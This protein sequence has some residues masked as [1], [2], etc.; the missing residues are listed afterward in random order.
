[1]YDDTFLRSQCYLNKRFVWELPF[2]EGYNVGGGGHPWELKRDSAGTG[3]GSQYL[4]DANNQTLWRLT[5]AAGANNYAST[6][7][8]WILWS[9][10][11]T[12][13]FRT[14]RNPEMIV[15]CRLQ[16]LTLDASHYFGF[17][18]L[19]AAHHHVIAYRGFH[20]NWRLYNATN[21]VNNIVDT[22]IAADTNW[23]TLK[24]KVSETKS[25]LYRSSSPTNYE[26]WTL[27]AENS[28]QMPDTTRSLFGTARVNT[29][30]T[31]AVQTAWIRR[32]M[33]SQDKV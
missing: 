7:Y 10:N 1:M 12:G 2:V 18:M 28:L 26:D 11:F 23:I 25:E 4:R 15:T 29:Q 17:S 14:N 3:S 19:A 20:T 33:F 21:S 22:G 13:G 16:T 24:L 9:G 31:G 8:N 27:I 32:W 6:S 5:S 30:L